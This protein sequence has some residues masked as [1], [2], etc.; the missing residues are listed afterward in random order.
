MPCFTFSGHI[1][2]WVI[3][4]V[5]DTVKA[6]IVAQVLPD[7]TLDNIHKMKRCKAYA[8]LQNHT[9]HMLHDQVLSE[10]TALH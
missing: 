2:G 10:H 4:H 8:M 7:W 9:A 3:A 1:R 5:S 6:T